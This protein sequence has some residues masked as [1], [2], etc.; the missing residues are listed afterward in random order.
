MQSNAVDALFYMSAFYC[1]IDLQQRVLYAV[2]ITLAIAVAEAVVAATA[3]TGI[4]AG[5]TS[6]NVIG[7]LGQGF[8][9]ASWTRM[10][11]LLGPGT[12]PIAY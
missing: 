3:G 9:S 4:V 1:T 11:C 12:H 8:P 6:S 10:S 2:A 7:P 5:T